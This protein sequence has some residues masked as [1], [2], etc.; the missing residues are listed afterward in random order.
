VKE[1][2]T[3]R[4][5]SFDIVKLIMAL[6]IA[7]FHL[8]YKFV[9][10]GYLSTEGF[11]LLGG[12]FLA[13]D[14]KI[15]SESY[16][17]LAV[18]K[19]G[20]IYP[21]YFFVVLLSLLIFPYA[22]TLDTL[23]KS[24]LM[25]QGIGFCD[26]IIEPLSPLWYLS[27]YM[28]CSLFFLYILKYIKKE[29]ALLLITFISFLSFLCMQIYNPGH[30]MNFTIE[31]FIAFPVGLLRGLA[32]M[33]LGIILYF[34]YDNFKGI[35]TRMKNQGFMVLNSILEIGIVVLMVKIMV[36][37]GF[38]SQYDMTFV[39]LFCAFIILLLLNTGLISQLLNEAGKQLKFSAGLSYSIYVFHNVILISAL[40]KMPTIRQFFLTYPIIY[41]V[42]VSVIGFAMSVIVNKI[43]QYLNVI[44][45]HSLKLNS[46]KA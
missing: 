4:I 28:W 32:E 17:K 38:T 36:F 5:Y 33:S 27:V 20:K 14:K 29:I 12:Y 2:N 9:P 37:S 40:R 35:W 39:I 44:Y 22:F 41:L 45:Q 19:I 31:H 6:V 43:V 46:S 42:V 11:F 21:L 18:H 26:I 16:S 1:H 15:F 8:Y 13:A 24:V 25:I 34:I 10:R 3:E 23:L 7:T 30:A